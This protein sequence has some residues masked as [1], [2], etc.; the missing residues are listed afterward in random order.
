V[1]S[2]GA[3][4]SGGSGGQGEGGGFPWFL[5]ALVGLPV[6]VLW[7][8]RR[9]RARVD[10]AELA[11]VK[12]EVE[13]DVLALAEEIRALDVDLELAQADP[14]ARDDYAAALDGY[15]RASRAL[16]RARTPEE[17]E[18]VAA[19]LEE[20]RYAMASARARVDGS[21]LPERRPPCFFDPRH[22]PSSRDVEWAPPDGV[23]RPVP[24]C[25]ADAQRVE[26]GLEPAAREVLV[27]GVRTPYWNAPSA[28]GPYAGGFFGGFG[29]IFPGFLIGTMLGSGFG[30][31]GADAG[32]ADGGIGDIGG[33]GGGDFGGFGGG[34]DVG[35]GGGDFGGGGGD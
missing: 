27:G 26:R 19:A 15:E 21:A 25:E 1:D 18:P 10:A 33:G 5:A 4:R 22:G 9:R 16:D 24:A 3:E 8:R 11:D 17:L 23:P 12:R 7:W 29:G 35:G 6:A 13:G 32:A 30:W 31:G 14:R 34:G 2:V 20:G 28:Y